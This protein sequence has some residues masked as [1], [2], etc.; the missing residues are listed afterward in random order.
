[1]DIGSIIIFVASLSALS[2]A[3]RYVIE[4]VEDLIEITN[5]GETSVGFAL[6][7]V[8]TST[9]ELVVALFAVLEETPALSVGDLLGSNVF[10]LGIVV[11]ML[12]LTA[13]F[14]REC[15]QGLDEIGD[16]LLLSS[17]IPLVLV[18]LRAPLALMG[19]GLL[20]VFAYSIY[21]E[22]RVKAVVPSRRQEY[23]RR[24]TLLVFAKI[25]AGTCVIV[26][27]ARFAVLSALQIAA[28]L[29]LSPIIIGAV[30]VAFGTSLPELSLSFAAVKR[31]RIHL[32]SANAIGSNL[33]NLTLILGIVFASSLFKPFTVD[34]ADFT[35]IISFVLI[36]SLILWYHMTKGG[37]CRLVG[38]ILILT[39]VFFQVNTI[40]R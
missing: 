23:S 33:T 18:I 2:L 20:G 16:V 14:L 12:M 22:T 27:A 28:L 26:L 19:F 38:L 36:S 35:E 34:V 17:I 24:T 4:Y 9:P 37:D 6:L 1:M 8:I 21:K 31:G 40:L 3:S 25:V 32:A 13:G 11:G 15:P 39:Y 29:G 30:I 7:S 10:N 5:L